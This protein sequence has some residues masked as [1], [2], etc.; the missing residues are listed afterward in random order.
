MLENIEKA[1]RLLRQIKRLSECTLVV[2]MDKSAKN[3]YRDLISRLGK[4]Q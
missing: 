2:P 3:S 1:N 4:H